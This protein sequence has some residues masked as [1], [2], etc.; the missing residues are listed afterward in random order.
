VR[1]L[2]G[3]G[4]PEE[5]AA[6]RALLLWLFDSAL[7]LLVILLLPP[8]PDPNPTSST[9][10]QTR[11][12]TQTLP[13]RVDRWRRANAPGRGWTSGA[14]VPVL[15][16]V[17]WCAWGQAGCATGLDAKASD[18]AGRHGFPKSGRQDWTQTTRGWSI[19]TG[20]RHRRAWRRGAFARA[21]ARQGAGR[22]GVGPGWISRKAYDG[23]GRYGPGMGLEAQVLVQLRAAHANVPVG[24]RLEI[25]RLEIPVP[26]PSQGLPAPRQRPSSRRL[27]IRRKPT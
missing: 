7:S 23:A 11:G 12:W 26:P 17:M 13:N 22:G 2:L 10:C 9:R 14:V 15:A 21:G 19:A 5:L 25:G 4:T 18:G 8:Q 16:P 27:G 3:A 6:R 24:V 20:K 1:A